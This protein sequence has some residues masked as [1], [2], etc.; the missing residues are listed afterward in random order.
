VQRAFVL[1]SIL[2]AGTGVAPGE[3]PVRCPLPNGTWR[4][5]HTEHFVLSTDL[6]ADDAD[7][8]AE[9]L[10]V[11]R[12]AVLRGLFDV[13]P[14]IPGPLRVVAFASV[15]DFRRFAPKPIQGY[16][17]RS[18]GGD[19]TIVVRGD[20]GRVTRAGLI[21]HELT[22]AVLARALPRRPPWLDEGLATY[23]EAIGEGSDGET[24]RL[25]APPPHRLEAARRNPVP[26]AEVLAARGLLDASQYATSWLLVH[27]LLAQQRDR[28]LAY[29]RRLARGEEP[30]AAWR[31]EFP[32]WDPASAASA[33]RL[34]QVL[35]GYVR[36]DGRYVETRFPARGE[37]AH[38]VTEL[39][40][41]EVRALCD[42]LPAMPAAAP[43]AP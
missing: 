27:Y 25:G 17:A 40:P 32:E 22:H 18:R 5:L 16:F 7:D 6:P 12:G 11:L 41:A 37:G 42:A 15:D 38:R 24:L 14:S 9:Q 43:P 4:E 20:L 10:E 36:D 2:L 8:L 3:G 29:E 26:V 34:D 23:V 35:L 19:A 13:P 31:T 21:A 39:S 28:F 33:T 1:L 30:A